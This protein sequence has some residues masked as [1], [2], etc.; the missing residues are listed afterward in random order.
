VDGTSPYFKYQIGE[1]NQN[2]WIE[3][4]SYWQYFNG[5]SNH[6]VYPIG[7]NN[8]LEYEFYTYNDQE[9]LNDIQ[10][11]PLEKLNQNQHHLIGLEDILSSEMSQDNEEKI[12]KIIM[13][14][15][16]A[17]QDS[18]NG[19]PQRDMNCNV[20]KY[21]DFAGDNV[22]S[23]LSEEKSTKPSRNL[24]ENFPPGEQA[25]G[26]NEIINYIESYSADEKDPFGTAGKNGRQPFMAL[27]LDSDKHEETPVARVSFGLEYSTPSIELL[28]QYSTASEGV[29]LPCKDRSKAYRERKKNKKDSQEAELHKLQA[30]NKDLKREVAIL[31]SK[32]KKMKKSYLEAIVKGQIICSNKM[33]PALI[34]HI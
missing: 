31:E 20:G 12:E 3:G 1:K 10:K 14:L 27:D 28:P 26:I 30:K 25:G 8:C 9:Q 34:N 32:V 33:L 5:H 2:E 16:N 17:S 24:V 4:Q 18:I 19:C 23:I 11:T 22:D 15:Q 6:Q 13:E 29:T 7:L 21:F